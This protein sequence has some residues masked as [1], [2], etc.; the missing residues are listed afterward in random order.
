M[1]ASC[2]VVVL[3]AALAIAGAAFGQERRSTPPGGQGWSVLSGQG[4][5]SDASVL[6]AEVGFPGLTL[7]YLRGLNSKV[8]IGGRF[9][10]NYAVENL[11][12]AIYPGVKAE[13]FARV[14]LI[15]TAKLALGL[16]LGAGAFGYFASWNSIAGVSLPVGLQLGIPVGSALMINAGLEMPLYVVFGTTGGLTLPILIGAGVEYFIDRRLAAT[17]HTR[18]GPSVNNTGFRFGSRGDLAFEAQFGVA[19]RL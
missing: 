19:Y 15:D 12:T 14:Q 9:F 1:R 4:V 10:F 11:I 13:V 8:D 6:V 18:I 7:A 16:E 17:F 3:V 2:K 5:G